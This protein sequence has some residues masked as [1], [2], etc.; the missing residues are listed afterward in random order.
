MDQAA[1]SQNVMGLV[2]S[3]TIPLLS[4]LILID[5]L[6]NE[7]I[8]SC[9]DYGKLLL[10]DEQI[11]SSIEYFLELRTLSLNKI[12]SELINVKI[13]DGKNGEKSSKRSPWLK[14]CII[15]YSESEWINDNNNDNINKKWWEEIFLGILIVLNMGIMIWQVY[16]MMPIL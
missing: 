14:S 13:R 2:S 4:S 7:E 6:I 10:I 16:K 1:F 15:N 8:D 5:S 11:Q 9:E 3:V 12:G